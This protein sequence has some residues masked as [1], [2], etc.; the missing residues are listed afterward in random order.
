MRVG[1]LGLGLVGVVFSDIVAEVSLSCKGLGACLRGGA[2]R[3]SP[4][5]GN[6]VVDL[7][8]SRSRWELPVCLWV[9][10]MVDLVLR[11]TSGSLYCPCAVAD[12]NTL[13][14]LD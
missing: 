2:I 9:S 11:P 13:V 4:G 10:D 7:C 12:I 8:P 14:F 1:D 5:R 3:P 6:C